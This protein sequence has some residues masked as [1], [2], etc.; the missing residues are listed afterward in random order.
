MDVF[1]ARQPIFNQEKEVTAYELLFR[2]GLDNFY[3]PDTDGDT[4]TLKVISNSFL[5][6]GLDTLTGGKPAFINFTRSHL[7]SRSAFS[8]PKNMISIEILENID[9]EEDVLEACRELKQSGY[10]IALDDFVFHERYIPF[11]ELAD[12]IKVDF[13]SL[14]RKQRAEIVKKC[15]NKDTIF[16]AEKV[17]SL[18]DFNEGIELGYQ[19]FQ[20]YFFSK[21][22]IITGKD[23]PSNKLNHMRILSE[24]NRPEM[25][26]QTV[27]DII[28][29]DI[30]L[31]YKLLRFINSAYFNISVEVNSIHHALVLLG[32]KEIKK[33]VSLMAISGMADD[34]PQ[35]LV[36]LSLV[37]AKFSESIAENIGY[38]SKSSDF[39][40]AG[41]FSVVDALLDKPFDEILEE[42]PLSVEIKNALKG[43]NNIFFNVLQLSIKY[44]QADWETTLKI[45][46][47]MKLDEKTLPELYFNALKWA[48]V[49][50]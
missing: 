22:V 23:I 37:R 35:E 21:P 28:K 48:N 19:Y 15:S 1:V 13:M 26:V 41:L 5:L 30:G 11:I 6:I 17:E 24:I 36:S 44:E 8:L 4:A 34:K 12:I 31:S 49:A 27:E 7:L 16:L 9:P 14:D 33:W 2:S 10:R 40:L 45:T 20:G 46:E 43:E 47:E 50:F 25:E 18:E 32:I 42:L 38:S 39:F 3:N 29:H